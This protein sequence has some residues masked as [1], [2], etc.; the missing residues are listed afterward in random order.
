MIFLNHVSK[1]VIFNIMIK[2]DR[3]NMNKVIQIL[4]NIVKQLT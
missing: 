4:T 1:I 2:N 3:N